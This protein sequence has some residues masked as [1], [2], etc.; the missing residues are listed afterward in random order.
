MLFRRASQLT[1]APGRPIFLSL[2]SGRTEISG[3]LFQLMRMPTSWVT[4]K[5]GL[6][7]RSLVAG[8]SGVA[9]MWQVAQVGAK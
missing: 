5:P 3:R 8:R 1:S 9:L 4:R 2:T 6:A 7:A